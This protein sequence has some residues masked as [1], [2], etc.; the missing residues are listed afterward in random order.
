MVTKGPSLKATSILSKEF[1]EGRL[2]AIKTI[3]RARN[4]GNEMSRHSVRRESWP[5]IEVGVLLLLL[6]PSFNISTGIEPHVGFVNVAVNA[7]LR[8]LGLL[9]LVLYWVWRNQEPFRTIGLAAQHP[10]REMLVGVVLYVPF[11]LLVGAI[12][13]VLEALGLPVA[14]AVPEFLIPH[15]SGQIALALLFLGVVAIAEEIL[16]RGY[17][18]HRLKQITG[19]LTAAVLISSL[20][21]GLGHGYQG[22]AGLVTAGLLGGI[23]AGIYLWRGSLVAPMVVHFL[24]NA[25]GI[26]LAPLLLH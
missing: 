16:F 18:I 22:A 6:M 11:L 26:L 9:A 21:F 7:I 4:Q 13:I 24:Q 1:S 17:L 3:F 23:L 20:L 8:D 15:G 10:S 25:T 12:R 5:A 14:E 19:N 2:A